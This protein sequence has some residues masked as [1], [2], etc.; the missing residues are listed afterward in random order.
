MPDEQP[1]DPPG[2]RPPAPEHGAPVQHSHHP[3]LPSI[4]FLEELKRRNVGRVAILYIVVSYVA[5]QVFELFF[6]LLELPAWAGRVAVIVIVV[7]F[8]VVLIFA[9]AY[10][11][12]PEG[13]KPTE[14]VAPHHSIR[15]HTGKRLDRA[16]IAVLA[17]ALTYFVVDKFWLS[18]HVVPAMVHTTAD[19]KATAASAAVPEK[20]VAVLPFLDMS[21][22]HDEEYF[23]DGL[24]EELIDMLTKVP[25]LRVPARTSSFYFKGKQTTIK[26]MAAALGVA[27]VLEG[28]VRKS[29]NTLRIT[30][31]LIR[32]DNGYHLWSETY[33]R[34]LDDI[35]KIQD[36]IAG[37]VV[38][39]LQVTLMKGSMPQAGGTANTEALILTM[40]AKAMW[41]SANTKGDYEKVFEYVQRS[42]NLDPAYAL[43]WVML[44]KVRGWQATSAWIPV[45][46]GWDESR[47]AAQ[48]ALALDPDLPAA[49]NAMANFH[50]I[51]DWDWAAAQSQIRE[52]LARDSKN[53]AALEMT[54]VISWY[55]G[56]LNNAINYMRRANDIDPLDSGGWYQIGVAYTMAG[57]FTEAQDALH[58]ALAINP[59]TTGAH[60]QLG[61]VLLAK[62]DPAAA[63]L[64]IDRETDERSRDGGRALAFHAL[65]RK[66][67]A[68]ST[69]ADYE[70]KYAAIDA[71]GIAETHAYRGE[72]DQAFQ[73]LDRAY[74][75]RDPSCPV[76]KTDLY[77]KNLRPDPRF[78]A[79]L[80]KMNLP[81]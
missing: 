59:G 30:A 48:R 1:Q 5:L 42:L 55:F 52:S 65:G 61:L 22:K 38:K 47:H 8:P 32:V 24:S 2:T 10:E 63:L 18:K 70:R 21:E 76:V 12:T 3:E 25:D 27:H 13:L 16:I 43:T 45:D 46:Q 79:F 60:A 41:I 68:D 72:I 31:Q 78:R 71:F 49:H 6:H 80:R 74:S 36:E 4:R 64:E 73:W 7:G 51:H 75:Q 28:S 69:L 29:G 58:R 19:V 50:L 23:S 9:W 66:A 56:D 17:I 67:D 14:D 33:D 20:S 57:R 54:G 81:D 37:A 40:Q 34:K 11:I 53:A 44:S 26:E 35:F 15:H 62:D 39:E 77:L